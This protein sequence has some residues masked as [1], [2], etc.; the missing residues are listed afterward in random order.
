MAGDVGGGLA[1][2]RV[3]GVIHLLHRFGAAQEACRVEITVGAGEEAEEF[4]EAPSRRHLFGQGAEM[5]FADHAGSVAGFFE[6]VGEGRFRQRQAVL[7]RGVELMAE[8]RLVAAGQE[9]GAGRRAVGAGDV[10][11]GEPDAGG[12]E[13]IEV[14]GWDV[15]AAMEPDVGVPHVVPDDDQDIRP[16]GGRQGEGEEQKQAAHAHYNTPAERRLRVM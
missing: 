14:R 2:E 6:S 12:G 16:V 1:S 5:P 15:F 4:L 13:R 7:A 3:G 11:V 8:T 10:A 9:G